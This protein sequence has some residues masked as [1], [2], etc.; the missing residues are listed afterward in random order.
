MMIVVE[1]GEVEELEEAG[2]AVDVGQC[3]L[4]DDLLHLNSIQA[5]LLLNSSSSS[6]R[7]LLLFLDAVEDVEMVAEVEDVVLGEE[8]VVVVTMEGDHNVVIL[9]GDTNLNIQLSN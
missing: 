6:I 1:I 4:L 9:V 5:A 7:D 3:H 8:A 2:A